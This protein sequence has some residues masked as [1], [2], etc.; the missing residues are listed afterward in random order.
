MSFA[1]EVREE[2]CRVM[3]EKRCCKFAECYGVLMFC[4]TFSKNEIKIITESRTFAELLPRLFRRT[5]GL[6]FD[7]FPSLQQP[8]KLTF[9]IDDPEKLS[10]IFSAYGQEHESLALH[11]NFA[12]LEDECCRQSFMRGAFL[13]GGSVTDP[14]K[15]Y[16]LELVTSHQKVGD[17]TYQL[18]LEMGFHPMDAQRSGSRILYFKRS[19]MIVD[20]LTAI[21]APVCA[22]KIIEAKVEKELRNGVNRRC[23]CDTANLGKAVDAAQQQLTAIRK[24]RDSGKFDALPEKLRDAAQLREENPEATLSELAAMASPPLSKPAM[25]HRMRKLIELS[26]EG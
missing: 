13:A 6:D 25:S 2:L 18:L 23:N 15:R 5:F 19:D 9:I 20:F 21:G 11:V 4:N 12:V 16:H 22:M 7:Q 26:T 8:G 1:S 24:L 3:P 14:D 10:Y 17:E